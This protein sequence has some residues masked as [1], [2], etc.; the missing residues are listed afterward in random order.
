MRMLQAGTRA[1]LTH[2]PGHRFVQP[3]VHVCGGDSL[4]RQPSSGSFVSVPI[5]AAYAHTHEH[6]HAP[7]PPEAAPVVE[8][9]VSQVSLHKVH[10]LAADPTGAA[11]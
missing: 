5:S 2:T 8:F 1:P 11:D 3:H 6:T 9:P 4:D 10:V 7:A